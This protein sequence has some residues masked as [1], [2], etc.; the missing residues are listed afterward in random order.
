M[1]G[2]RLP[3]STCAD[4]QTGNGIRMYYVYII[5]STIKNWVYVG[6]TENIDKRLAEHNS[7]LVKST[8][9]YRP[10]RL[11]FV[12]IVMSRIEARDFEKYC[13]VRWNKE[14]I[15]KLISV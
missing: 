4:R 10:F 6:N 13:K 15:V 8:K 2:R 7:G 5:K 12:Q 9:S 3:A 14:S 11:L 1:P